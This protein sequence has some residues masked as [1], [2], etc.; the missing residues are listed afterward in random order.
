MLPRPDYY[1]HAQQARDAR[2]L[3]QPL[4]RRGVAAS[5]TRYPDELAMFLRLCAVVATL[6]ALAAC[7]A[8][9][10]R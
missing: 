2:R 8:W 9:L 6:T 5:E 4:D 1:H 10:P 3:S 7:I